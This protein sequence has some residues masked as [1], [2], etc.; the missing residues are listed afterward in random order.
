MVIRRLLLIMLPA[1]AAGAACL[2]VALADP[3]TPSRSSAIAQIT[4]DYAAMD[5]AGANRDA[6]GIVKYLSSDYVEVDD[7]GSIEKRPAVILGNSTFVAQAS[8]ITSRR[9][10]TSFTLRGTTAIVH[11]TQVGGFD[12][13]QSSMGGPSHFRIRQTEIDTWKLT[14]TGW[15]MTRTVETSN[16]VTQTS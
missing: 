14:P 8:N 7:K 9:S 5:A 16:K 2:H 11:M 13:I 6:D 3:K 1:A 4:A 12:L 10:I 15:R